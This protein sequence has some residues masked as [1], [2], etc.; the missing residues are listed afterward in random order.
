MHQTFKNGPREL[1]NTG[2]RTKGFAVLRYRAGRR[3]PCNNDSQDRAPKGVGPSRYESRCQLC[4][5]RR[6]VRLEE[7]EGE[8]LMTGAL[9]DIIIPCYNGAQYLS[10]A[11]DSALAQ[12]YR[13]I[14]VLVVDDGSTDHTKKVVESYGGRVGYLYQSN[15]GLP[16]ARN[17]GILNTSGDYLTFLDADDIL[18]PSRTAHQMQVLM[19]HNDLDII[20]G[21]TLRVLGHDLNHPIPEDWRPYSPWDDFLIPL[22]FMCPISIH[23]ALI[24]RRVFSE[25]GMFDARMTKG[26][27]DWAFWLKCTLEGARIGYIP[28]VSG[29]YRQHESA[30]CAQEAKIA[31]QESG[32]ME[33]ALDMFRQHGVTNERHLRVLSCGIRY[34]GLKWLRLGDTKQ[35]WRLTDLARI[36]HFRAHVDRTDECY[37]S[38]DLYPLHHFILARELYRLGVPELSLA[39]LIQPGDLG[40][41]RKAAVKGGCESAFDEMLPVFKKAAYVLAGQEVRDAEWRL[42]L[43]P[44]EP[45]GSPYAAIE[46]ALPKE[47][48][49][50]VYAL[51]QFSRLSEAFGDHK[52]ALQE[53]GWAIY[54]NPYCYDLLITHAML[55]KREGRYSRALREVVSASSIDKRAASHFL[56]GA[57]EA[58]FPSLLRGCSAI[59]RGTD[60]LLRTVFRVA[61]LYLRKLRQVCRREERNMPP[62]HSTVRLDPGFPYRPSV[63]PAATAAGAKSQQVLSKTVAVVTGASVSEGPVRPSECP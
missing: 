24:R 43:V 60:L 25:H 34:I 47:A 26:C 63:P 23:S 44:C 3:A 35:F 1:P 56:V 5:Y 17:T 15:R 14:K 12:T 57:A 20:Y 37:L 18:M 13:P 32:L 2:G 41:I 52:A 19:A 29:F 61:L 36:V 55:L 49:M 46:R 8:K 59:H 40:R 48:S 38:A 7:S 45:E 22:S 50:Y 39:C 33:I 62:L 10:S 4:E 42:R 58:A 54:Y 6:G 11:I 16:G 31:A 53:L 30:M 28:E 21:K 9:V 27:E 51:H